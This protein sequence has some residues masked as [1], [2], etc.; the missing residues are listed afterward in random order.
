MQPWKTRSHEKVLDYGR[1][2]VVEKHTIELPD[3]RT[4]SDWP[5][6]ITPIM[7]I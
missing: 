6:L 7:S 1:F 4:L 2:L 5:W 3:G